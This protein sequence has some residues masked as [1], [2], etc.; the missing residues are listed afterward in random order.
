M[1]AICIRVGDAKEAHD[2]SV[3][4]GA[5]SIFSPQELKDRKTGDTV[6]IS[7]IK[8]VGKEEEYHNIH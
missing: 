4:Y 2:V 8:S 6:W 1:R 5:I 7:E 3:K